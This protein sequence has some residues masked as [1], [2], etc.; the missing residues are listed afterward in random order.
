MI[1]T[2]FPV[3]KEKIVKNAKEA[4]ETR[5]RLFHVGMETTEEV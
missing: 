3:E 5:L 2:I 4:W 1:S